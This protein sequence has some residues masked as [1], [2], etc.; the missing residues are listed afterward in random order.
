MDKLMAD[1]QNKSEKATPHKLRE[2]KKKGQAAKSIEISSLGLLLVFWGAFIA[3]GASIAS[4][5]ADVMRD[6]I[7]SSSSISI[8]TNSLPIIGF[9]LAKKIAVLMAPVLVMI[10]IAAFVVNIMQTGPIL[11]S[12]PIKPDWNRLNP[13]Q[14]FKKIISIK[15]LFDLFKAILKVGSIYF[16][17]VVFGADWLDKIMISYGMPVDNF[18]HHWASLANSMMLLLIG[19][20]IPLAVLDFAFARWDFAKKMRMSTQDIKDEFKKREGDPLVKQKQ[21]QIQKEL[22]KKAAALNNVKDAD[23]IITNPEHIAVAIQYIPRKMLAPKVLALGEDSHA[24]TIRSIARK[25]N[26]PIVRNIPLARKIYKNSV[27]EGF[28]P[29]SSYNEVAKVLKPIFAQRKGFQGTNA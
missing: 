29:E 21:K 13:V 25:Y 15:T 6:L 20:L 4:G 8:S 5:L 16:A 3:F 18:V 27:I 24:A 7:L 2:A 28:I 17:W 19:L 1:D 11:S 23:V 10:I 12:H 22:L 14:G 9:D 26:V